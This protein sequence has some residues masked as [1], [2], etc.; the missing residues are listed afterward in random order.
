MRLLGRDQGTLLFRASRDLSS[1]LVVMS[2]LCCQ[3]S[4]HPL[5][6]SFSVKGGDASNAGVLREHPPLFWQFVKSALD[7]SFAPVMLGMDLPVR[8]IHTPIERHSLPP[9][10]FICL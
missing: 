1:R 4:R 10:F 3:P 5:N 7:A 9:I 8:R 2:T 6:A